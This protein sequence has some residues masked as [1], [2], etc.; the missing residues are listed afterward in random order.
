MDFYSEGIDSLYS[1]I[2]KPYTDDIMKIKNKIPIAFEEL[3]NAMNHFMILT[4][5][6]INEF[7]V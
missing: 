4:L 2:Y 3:C 5:I 1:A 6:N 7:L